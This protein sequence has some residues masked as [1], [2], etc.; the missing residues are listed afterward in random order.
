MIRID[1]SL[2]ERMIMLIKARK[3]NRLIEAERYFREEHRANLD[4]ESHKYRRNIWQSI[5]E[6][7]R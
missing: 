3:M 7:W 2:T 5:K 1:L 4:W 6:M